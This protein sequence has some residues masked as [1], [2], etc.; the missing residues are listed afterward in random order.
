MTAYLLDPKFSNSNESSRLRPDH[1]DDS[2][3]KL[4][5]FENPSFVATVLKFKA[6]TPPF[7]DYLSV[8]ARSSRTNKFFNMVEVTRKEDSRNFLDFV[9]N[10]FSCVTSSAGLERLF[11]SYGIV[12]SKLRNKLG[13][14][15]CAKLVRYYI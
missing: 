11:S 6:R 2:A 13:V 15:K 14:E 4:I 1:E 8:F 9:T 10:V 3:M 7:Q 5:A 12:Q